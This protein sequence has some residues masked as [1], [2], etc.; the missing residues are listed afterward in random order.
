[1]SMVQNPA[2]QTRLS[3]ALSVSRPARL[4]HYDRHREKYVRQYDVTG[5]IARAKEAGTLAGLIT[6]QCEFCGQEL[7]QELHQATGNTWPSESM[8]QAELV[9]LKRRVVVLQLI[10]G[11][12]QT[13]RAPCERPSRIV[14]AF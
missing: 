8:L 5:K 14:S 13:K 11:S 2:A 3:A 6:E 7:A 10:L 4:P 12:G 9:S 1:M